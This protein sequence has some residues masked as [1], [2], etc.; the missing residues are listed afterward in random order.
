LGMTHSTFANPHGLTDKQHKM[1]A[2]DLC[3][4]AHQALQIPLFRQIVATRQ[5]GC[6]VQ[7]TAGYTR[8]VK[9]ENTNEL[10]ATEGYLG[11]KTGTTSAAGACLVSLA[12]RDNQSRICVILGSGNSRA[13]YA[14]TRNLLRWSW[15]LSN[16]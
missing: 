5:R 1:S 7:S 9:W 3:L 14:D 10:L 13:R 15:S 4:L 6:I 11:V 16:P 12:E 2:N 8:N